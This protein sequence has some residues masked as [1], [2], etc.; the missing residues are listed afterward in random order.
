MV[1]PKKTRMLC[2]INDIV[3]VIVNDYCPIRTIK[4]KTGDLVGH[5]YIYEDGLIKE[6]PEDEKSSYVEY[7]QALS[8]KTVRPK[9]ARSLKAE[10]IAAKLP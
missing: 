8:R 9:Y 1:Q 4:P 6:L 7:A 3:W 2:D 5:D 10:A